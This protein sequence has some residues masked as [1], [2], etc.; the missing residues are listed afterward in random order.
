MGKRMSL[1][2]QLA[3]ALNK[4]ARFGQSKH[5]AKAQERERCQKTGDT[6]NPSRAPGIHSISTME[7]YKKEGIKFTNWA[8]ATHGCR[9]LEETK[10]HVSQYL[11]EGIER[12]L[13]PWTLQLQRAA[14]R[15]ALEDNKI[16]ADVKLPTRYRDGVSRSRGDKPMDREFSEHRNRD[17][18]DFS[19]ATGLRRH[20]MAAL[21]RGDVK[22]T[23]DG[24]KV[25][26]KQGKGGRPREVPV[27]NSYLEKIG[28]IVSG[29]EAD[30]KL[31]ERIPVRADI[32]GYRR[33]YAAARYQELAG[34]PFDRKEINRDTIRQ[35]S[36]D[37]GHNREDVV[38]RSYL[39]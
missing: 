21:K 12:G 37:L 32:H 18:V 34:R 27:L 9:Y 10:T 17:L 19:K 5:V 1:T 8:K 7:S 15:K 6:Y 20:E 29:K 22:I 24:L 11:R 31:F 30:E 16:A 35:I 4:Q 38:I 25:H 13:S 39:D 3:E 23:E 14:L 36:Q 2:K 26:V 28:S 33:E